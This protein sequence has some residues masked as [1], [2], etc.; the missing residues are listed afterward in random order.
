MAVTDD[1]D[2]AVLMR[3]L[4]NHGRDPVYLA[5][6][7]GL[8]A[9]GE[10]LRA[11]MEGRFRFVRPGASYRI[12]ELEAAL[13]VAQLERSAGLLAARAGN[14]AFLTAGLRDLGEAGLLQLPSAPPGTDRVFMFYPLVVTAEDVDRDEVTF[15]LE[16]RGIETRP[17]MPLV[18]QP[19]YAG[20]FAG[21]GLPVARWLNERAFCIGCHPGLSR[22][23]LEYMI[24]ALRSCLAGADGSPAS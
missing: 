19:V 15:F 10:D 22:A 3:S 5:I 21:T 11:V 18:S 14:A 9:S 23:D 20:L 16:Q 4:C 12:T 6:E 7:D 13:G 8:E 17:L 1:E 2:L 24:D